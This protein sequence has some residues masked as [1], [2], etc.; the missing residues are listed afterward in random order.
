MLLA[1]TLAAVLWWRRRHRAQGPAGNVTQNPAVIIGT[2]DKQTNPGSLMDMSKDIKDA[3]G[4]D[5][6]VVAIPDVCAAARSMLALDATDVDDLPLAQQVQVCWR[7]IFATV[8]AATD[9]TAG[10]D[11]TADHD[12]YLAVG[13][14]AAR[15]A[16]VA[17]AA[18]HAGKASSDARSPIVPATQGYYSVVAAGGSS[19]ELKPAFGAAK[20]P[21]IAAYN[22]QGSEGALPPLPVPVPRRGY[23]KLWQTYGTANRPGRTAHARRGEGLHPVAPTAAVGCDQPL[24][25]SI[26]NDYEVLAGDAALMMAS[27]MYQSYG[28]NEVV[29]SASAF[30]HEYVPP[31]KGK[32]FDYV[33]SVVL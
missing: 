20:P 13:A 7:A 29:M 11:G 1:A 6:S 3:L 10:G 16:S 30:Y 17:A 15:R 25:M 26:K 33:K 5:R 22:R 2:G 12:G 27:D 31:V 28:G 19:E 14:A 32:N 23:A 9:S 4:L 8:D 18:N 21:V 24:A